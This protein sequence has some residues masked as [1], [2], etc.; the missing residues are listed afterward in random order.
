[1]RGRGIE[2]HGHVVLSLAPSLNWSEYDASK[3]WVRA[4][5]NIVD[6]IRWLGNAAAARIARAGLLPS[7]GAQAAR[8]SPSPPSVVGPGVPSRERVAVFVSKEDRAWHRHVL[9]SLLWLLV[10]GLGVAVSVG[11]EGR[12]QCGCKRGS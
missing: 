2:E 3:Q 9:L 5:Q 12:A 7:G 4:R 8:V 1:M 10:V 11:K 6:E